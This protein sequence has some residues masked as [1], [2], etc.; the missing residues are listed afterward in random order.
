MLTIITEKRPPPVYYPLLEEVASVF[1]KFRPNPIEETKID[2]ESDPGSDTYHNFTAR[3]P[4]ANFEDSPLAHC[5]PLKF[6]PI[7][8]APF[9]V[10]DFFCDVKIRQTERQKLQL[11]RSVQ[12][13][14]PPSAPILANAGASN[15]VGAMVP[16]V[17]PPLP[18]IKR[19][20]LMVLPDD[21]ILSPRIGEYMFPVIPP[22]PFPPTGYMP[23]PL[24]ADNAP[25]T[26]SE[27]FS[28]WLVALSYAP[29]VD[30]VLASAAGSIFDIRA[31]AQRDGL[32]V[33][34]LDRI[35]KMHTKDHD[36]F[37]EISLASSDSDNNSD[38]ALEEY[39][40]FAEGVDTTDEFDPNYTPPRENVVPVESRTR[41][42][43]QQVAPVMSIRGNTVNATV[44]SPIEYSSRNLTDAPDF[45]APPRIVP[46]S[47]Q[48]PQ[49]TKLKSKLQSYE[50]EIER[51][52]HVNLEE[53]Y[54][55]RKRQLLKKLELLQSSR[56]LYGDNDKNVRDPDLRMYME[57][58][59]AQ[60]DSEL[61]QLKVQH[62]YDKLKVL[63][64]FYQTSHRLYK[65][66]NAVLVNK[67]K[68]LRNFLEFQQLVF[69]EASSERHAG[70][71]DVTS[72]KGRESAKLYSNFVEQDYSAEIKEVF[73][74]SFLRKEGEEI[75]NDTNIDPSDYLK[76][77]TDRE[78]EAIV[79]DYMPMV[80]ENEFKLITGEAPSKTGVSKDVANKTKIARHMIFQ[81]AL[82]DYGTSGS[83]TN[84]SEN[85]MPVKRRPGRRAAP[86]PAYGEEGAKLLNDAALVAK[87]MKL[88]VGPA[89][90]NVDEL[91]SDLGLI[92]IKTKWPLK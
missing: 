23:Y 60:K 86:K 7:I 88:F 53:I 33:Q 38:D 78:H 56:I 21:T 82:Y 59:Q 36:D 43:Y 40:E 61:L 15:S 35:S 50:E 3:G 39:M 2:N 37:S 24:V 34:R 76:V 8:Q 91:S 25:L 52:A 41:I 49:D 13:C 77:Y 11:D 28:L 62:T 65:T 9:T 68:K 83:D 44:R 73:R 54:N 72:I 20:L 69:D 32:T 57:Q 26:P 64:G 45:K 6:Q 80:T 85:P 92:G 71:G 30:M 63:M 87:I 48:S 4:H 66:M 22:L 46:L 19:D 1:K 89:G 79:D 17:Y 14:P 70:E 31:Q 81:N 55:T 12:S 27:I 74:C 42:F 84:L 16:F 18:P 58:R 51:V 10:N 5:V 67:L 90:A 75:E 47:S 29:R